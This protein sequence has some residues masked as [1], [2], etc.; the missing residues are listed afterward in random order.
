ME[1]RAELF[2]MDADVGGTRDLA[3]DELSLLR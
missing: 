1:L 2:V 3:E